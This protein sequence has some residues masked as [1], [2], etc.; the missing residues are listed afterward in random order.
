[1]SRSD[2]TMTIYPVSENALLIS[3]LEQ[4]CPIQHQQITAMAQQINKSLSAY[5]IETIV[6]YNTLQIYY[7]FD[8]I[9]L[10]SLEHKLSDIWQEIV[11][12]TERQHSQSNSVE[13]P[14][15][16]GDEVALDMDDVVKHTQ[17]DR[18]TIIKQHSTRVY[19][20]FALGFT[21]GFCYL[22]SLP[23]QLSV[24]RKATPRLSIPKGAVAIAEQQTAVYPN[25]SP[26]G[27]HIIGQTPLA[28]YQVIEQQFI[29]TIAVGDTV[30]FVPIDKRQFIELGGVFPTS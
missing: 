6:S 14:V 26:G 8:K 21:P 7:H 20:A 3:W 23:K 11:K 24:A 15:Y 16:Y 9:T 25:S 18:A 4:I 2:P 29:P 27:W 13:I 5:L 30:K 22:G 1:M 17:L 28:M 10:P 19:H 12:H